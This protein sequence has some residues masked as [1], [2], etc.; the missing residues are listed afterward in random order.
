MG[1]AAARAW[2]RPAAN[3]E[4][5]CPLAAFAHICCGQALKK[6]GIVC[7]V[8][9]A[10]F[11]SGKAGQQDPFLGFFQRGSVGIMWNDV[12]PQHLV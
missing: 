12:S 1:D 3:F 11:L 10:W 5:R 4:S 6:V 8:F 9:V 2:P 7:W